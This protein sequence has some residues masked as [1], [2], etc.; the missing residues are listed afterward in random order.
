[1]TLK[2][3]D[4]RVLNGLVRHPLGQT[5]LKFQRCRIKTMT[6]IFYDS[7]GKVHKEF[8][9]EGKTVNAEFYKGVKIAS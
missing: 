4:N 1:M 5:K 7:Q 9:P 8:V 3:S 6:T 2:Q